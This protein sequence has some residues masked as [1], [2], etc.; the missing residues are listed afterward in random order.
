MGDV[1]PD[2]V[3]VQEMAPA[4]EGTARAPKTTGY[5]WIVNSMRQ[6]DMAIAVHNGWSG[7][8]RSM[9]QGKRWVSATWHIDGE[10]ITVASVRMPTGEQ[11]S[12]VWGPPWSMWRRAREG[13]GRTPSTMF[14]AGSRKLDLH[15]HNEDARHL[16][17]ECL[18]KM[19]MDKI[20]RRTCFGLIFGGTPRQ[21][22]DQA[23]A[24]RLSDEPG[25]LHLRGGPCTG[26]SVHKPVMLARHNKEKA[27]FE[28]RGGDPRPLCCRARWWTCDMRDADAEEPRCHEVD[29]GVG[30]RDGR[31]HPGGL[32]TGFSEH[33]AAGQ[34]GLVAARRHPRTSRG[35]AR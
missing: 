16:V 35:S 14:T 23:R 33:P 13:S 31:L 9:A 10:K 32:A 17:C 3:S 6:W 2:I 27:K 26:R 20:G 30:W 24:R 29:E 34:E 5:E 8:I 21:G 19:K 11:D 7:E 22:G 28:K 18:Q 15:R 1:K 4:W 12:E 25:A